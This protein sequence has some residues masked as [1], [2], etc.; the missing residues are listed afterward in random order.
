[1]ILNWFP[2]G[3]HVVQKKDPT[4]TGNFEITVDG[5]LVHSKKTQRQGFLEQASEQRQGEVKAAIAEVLQGMETKKPSTGDIK[6]G[7]VDSGGG[8][9]IC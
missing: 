7:V 8:C 4:T 5:K 6:E 9:T 3:V 1:M 2:E